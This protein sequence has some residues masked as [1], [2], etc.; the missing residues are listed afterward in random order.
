M[1][2]IYIFATI[3][4]QQNAQKVI[5]SHLFPYSLFDKK[6]QIYLRLAVLNLFQS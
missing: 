6:H 1:P 3:L 4:K 2:F 5:I